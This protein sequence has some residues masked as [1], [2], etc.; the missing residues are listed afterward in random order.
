MTGIQSEIQNKEIK[1]M[2]YRHYLAFI[3]SWFM[4]RHIIHALA[5]FALTTL[6]CNS[7][8]A[9]EPSSTLIGGAGP[10][11]DGLPSVNSCN[12]AVSPFHLPAPP[13]LPLPPKTVVLT[14]DDG[15]DIHTL[16]LA[17]YL[18]GKA[19]TATFFVN[20]CRFEDQSSHCENTTKMDKNVLATLV[21]YGHR[22]ANHSETHILFTDPRIS[23]EQ[24]ISELKTTQ[25]LLDPFIKDGFYFFRPGNNC[26]SQHEDDL[27]RNSNDP[28]LEKL[29]GPFGYDFSGG[30]WYCSE[31]DLDPAVCALM[32]FRSVKASQNGIIQMH[33]RPP[34]KVGTDYALRVTT[35]LLEGLNTKNCPN[36]VNSDYSAAGGSF[37]P[38]EQ[39]LLQNFRIVPLDA[40]PGVTSKVANPAY[41]D[42]VYA[43][44]YYSDSNGW[45]TESR[46][47][48]IRLADVNGDGADDACGR[49]KNGLKCTIAKGDG[50]FA[51]EKLFQSTLTDLY[52]YAP[53]KYGNTLQFGDIDAD[54]KADA[55][56]RGVHGLYCFKS[57]GTSFSE[58]VTWWLPFFSDNYGWGKHE[59][60]YG[61]IRIGH[62]NNDSYADVCGRKEEGVYCVLGGPNGPTQNATLWE[63]TQ[64][65]DTQGWIDVKYGTTF[66]LADVNGDRLDDLCARSSYGIIC[67]LSNG[68]SFNPPEHWAYPQFGDKDRWGDSPSRYGSIRFKDINGDGNADVC[69]RDETGI[70]CAISVPSKSAFLYPRY[71]QN[72]NFMDAWGWS[73]AAYGA[74]LLIGNIR[75]THQADICARGVAGLYCTLAT[76]ENK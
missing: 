37:T 53:T 30:D 35:C 1:I 73:N 7:A 26:W 20:G 68:Q 66:Q 40:I 3:T 17:K 6:P 52:G 36:P 14:Y 8:L 71:V 43:S 76:L 63:S 19:V 27:I 4:K 33:D 69:G 42:P 23:D 47:A 45:K 56:I 11:P 49:D 41:G 28:I 24:R 60:Y 55:C 46:Y 18:A 9:F 13:S 65:V 59:S 25:Q 32:Y 10:S 5:L 22:I 70:L 57:N 67:A 44:S 50:T 34:G 64:F 58:S 74:T 48:S 29:V 62:I 72:R 2:N 39:P 12:V 21:S 51:A 75:N 31:H 54:G 15:P 16:A 61:S 38:A